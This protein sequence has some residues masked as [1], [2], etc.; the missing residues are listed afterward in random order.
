MKDS[1][2]STGSL[3]WGRHEDQQSNEVGPLSSTDTDSLKAGTLLAERFKLIKRVSATGSMTEWNASDTNLDRTVRVYVARG[4]HSADCADAA[5]R[6]SALTDSRVARILDIGTVD[7]SDVVY[8]V[9]ELFEGATLSAVL[10]RGAVHPSIARAVVGDI[11]FCLHRASG[12]GLHHQQLT[13]GSVVQTNDGDLR[14]T[15]LAI[16]AAAQGVTIEDKAAEKRDAVALARLLYHCLTGQEWDGSADTASPR[17]LNSGAPKELDSLCRKALLDSGSNRIETP[18]DFAK[19]LIPWNRIPRRIAPGVPT[20]GTVASSSLAAATTF[21][22]TSPKRP[23]PHRQQK[24]ATGAAAPTSGAVT[25]AKAPNRIITY[26]PG[27]P[28]S[29]DNPIQP[30]RPN[31]PRT[32]RIVAPPTLADVWRYDNPNVEQPLAQVRRSRFIGADKSPTAKPAWPPRVTTQ[33]PKENFAEAVCAQEHAVP[34]RSRRSSHHGIR[35]IVVCAILLSIAFGV[36]AWVLELGRSQSK[37]PQA[38]PTTP[39]FLTPTPTA[40]ETPTPTAS[41]TPT[42]TA[43]PTTEPAGPPASITGVK[44]LDPEGDGQ[45]NNE[46]APLMLDD[47]PASTW[48]SNS[49][50]D[51]TFAT[52]KKGLGIE[53]TWKPGDALAG[54]VFHDVGQGGQIEIREAAGDSVDGPV[55]AN[56]SANGASQDINFEQPLTSGR[57]VIWY[58]QL[59]ENKGKFRAEVATL[60]AR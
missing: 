26:S 39:V 45:E 36:A 42:A 6:V 3:T 11:A 20:D 41:E 46:R 50:G 35:L 56:V 22:Y 34:A 19:A 17:T 12:A 15:G 13:A 37:A 47:N 4:E 58:T 8:I 14:L 1:A 57:L 51:A 44:P 43:E 48:R 27:E 30:R 21:G 23:T 38:V 53:V 16:E 59:P 7:D 29:L 60:K 31:S 55:V 25:K 28:G 49:Y 5:R 18:G 32:G 54:L 9:Q 24:T 10:K 2:A 33:A 52:L 40:T